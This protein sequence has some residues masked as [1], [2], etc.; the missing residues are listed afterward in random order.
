LLSD[1]GCVISVISFGML[2]DVSSTSIWHFHSTL[3]LNLQSAI[4]VNMKWIVIVDVN[5]DLTD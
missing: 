3:L 1:G 2:L 5:F 4:F